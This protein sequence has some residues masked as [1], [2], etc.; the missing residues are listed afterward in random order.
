MGIDFIH[1]LQSQTNWHDRDLNSQG[2]RREIGRR[3]RRGET[4][5]IVVDADEEEKGGVAPVHDLVVPVLHERTLHQHKNQRESQKIRKTHYPDPDPRRS[6]T[7]P[8]GS[9]IQ[10]EG[11]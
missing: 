7:K 6:N 3:R 2:K 8:A 1:S 9:W 4:H 11:R 5:L 10:K